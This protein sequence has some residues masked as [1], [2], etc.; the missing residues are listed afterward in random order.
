MPSDN[1]HT[2]LTSPE[3]ALAVPRALGR[4]RASCH[5]HPPS[6]CLVAT[7][8]NHLCI[9]PTTKTPRPCLHRRRVWGPCRRAPRAYAFAIAPGRSV[10]PSA[11]PATH[12]SVVRC[13][14]EVYVALIIKQRACLTMTGNLVSLSYSSQ[15]SLVPSPSRRQA[16]SHTVFASSSL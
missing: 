7:A 9:V 12:L 3:L 14:P 4:P 2:P 13:M 6:S 11:A 16:G 8:C 15:S 5:R 10:A 1:A